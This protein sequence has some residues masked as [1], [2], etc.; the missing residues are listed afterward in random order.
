MLKLIE[1]LQAKLTSFVEQRDDFLLIVS[2]SDADTA[3]VLKILQDVE[4][5]NSTDLFV[6]FSDAFESQEQFAAIV[7][8]RFAEQ[9]KIACDA[10]V[11]DGSEP[12]PPIPESARDIEL[13]PERRLGLVMMYAR[14]LIPREGGHRV[15]WAM[16][17]TAIADRSA[18]LDLVNDFAP[19]Q[20]I[21]PGMQGLRLVFRDEPDT[22]DFFPPLASAPRVQ[23]HPVDMGP[24]ALQQA[25]REEVEDEELPDERR[26][27]ALLQNAIIDAA[28]GR[29]ED[30]FA[31][32]H[33]LLGHYQHTKNAPMQ[34]LVINAFGDIHHRDN[35]LEQARHCYECAVPPAIESKSAVILQMVTKNLADVAFT[36]KAYEDAEQLY[37]HTA[38]LSGKML[39]TE[40][41]AEA[42]ERR[43]LCQEQLGDLEAAVDS[44][45]QAAAFT[46]NLG[47]EERLH[48]NLEHLE[49]GYGVLQRTDQLEAVRTELHGKR[50]Q[51]VDAAAAG[52]PVT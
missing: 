18:Y 29:K 17:P 36:T 48:A 1:E 3:M 15:I 39:H 22:G 42:L 23:M 27:T 19:H 6:L 8:E 9:H 44:W 45:E 20:G 25:L 34:A 5:A 28:H 51:S 16:C 38:E 30:A 35:D 2:C 7:I 26:M 14:S 49:R 52:P 24:E 33:V 4:Q 31:Q 21:R 32:F 50:R 13:S 46:R 10:L 41:R 43:G 11:E 47:I 12:W 40:G 37:A